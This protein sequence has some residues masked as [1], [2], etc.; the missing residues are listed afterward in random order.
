M[1]LSKYISRCRNP[2]VIKNKHGDLVC[3]SCNKCPDCI[4]RKLARY[5]ALCCNESKYSQKT[6]FITLT[7]DDENIPTMMLKRVPGSKEKKQG[8]YIQ[9]IDKTNRYNNPLKARCYHFFKDRYDK[10]Y[11]NDPFAKPFPIK[12]FKLK[13]T[14]SY[15]EELHR[16]YTTYSDPLFKE[17]YA[18][19]H[20]RD[21]QYFESKKYRWLPY[22]CKEDL[23]KFIKRLRFRIASEYNTEV[24]FY[25]IGEYGPEH[26]RP[27]YHI[28]LFV[29]EPRLYT[30]LQR[31][32][33][34]CWQYGRTDCEPA[35]DDSGCASYV[36]SYANSISTLPTFLNGTKIAPFSLHSQNFGTLY[37]DKIR[38]YVYSLKQYPFESFD[39]TIN[40]SLFRVSLSDV[41]AYNFFPRCY[42]YERQSSSRRL[43]LYTCYNETS[44]KYNFTRCSDLARVIIVDFE[45][46]RNRTLLRSL[47]IPTDVRMDLMAEDIITGKKLDD[48]QITY[49]NR[50]Y[51]A[52]ST[53]KLFCFNAKSPELG[54]GDPFKNLLQRIEDFYQ[55]KSFNQ[56]S[57]QYI[58]EQEYYNRFQCDD[59]D[60]FYPIGIKGNYK[61]DI[62]DKNTFIKQFNFQKDQEYAKKIKHKKQNDKNNIFT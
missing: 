40:A 56:L 42:N 51:S 59:Y 50:I 37:N 38:D 18:K 46:Y 47:D 4:A 6:F 12:R 61:F 10:K 35:R 58:M 55:Q 19:V 62:Y 41:I 57:Q 5:T 3:C 52:L 45:D 60:I 43:Q 49:Y 9:F 16:V 28:N 25:A 15:N 32:V 33:A 39:V 29:N 22:L 11:G 21:S 53:S 8:G 24:R 13:K 26:F 31:I 20:E 27:H 34:D 30:E 2:Q 44:R 7:Y 54:E 36:A 17:F 14:H 23:Q 48:V 1:E